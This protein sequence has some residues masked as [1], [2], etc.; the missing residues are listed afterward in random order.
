[1]DLGFGLILT[2]RYNTCKLTQFMET[3]FVHSMAKINN[4]ESVIFSMIVDRMT[5]MGRNC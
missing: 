1:M 2:K 4:I 3:T 5:S